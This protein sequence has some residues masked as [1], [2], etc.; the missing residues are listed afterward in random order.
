VNW[1]SRG[2]WILVVALLAVFDAGQA[3]ADELLEKYRKPV[4][5]GLDWLAKQQNDKGYWGVSAGNDTYCISM[6]A[7]SGMALLMEGSTI[8]EGKYAANIRKAT[9]FLMDKCQD[10]N[11]RDGLIGDPTLPN[12]Q[13]RYM[14]GH[15]FGLMFL[16]SVYGEEQDAKK[17]ARLKEILTRAVK[18]CINAQSTRGGWYYTSA[19]DGH[20]QDEG[21]VT[22]TQVQALRAARNAGI[23]VPRDVIRKCYEYLKACT[24]PRGAVYYSW[25]SKSERAAITAAAVACLFNAGEYKDELGKKWLLFCKDSIPAEIGGIGGGGPRLGH[26]E[27]THYYYAQCLYILGDGGWE[28]LF[29]PTAPAQRV[30]WTTYRNTLCDQLVR[31][32]NQDGSWSSAGGFSVGPVYSTAM[33]LTIMQLDKG[34]LPIYQR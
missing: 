33:Y 13:A 18:Y 34:V 23:P 7:L 4:E 27:Y 16:A 6:T 1:K 3:R 31:L 26:D 19:K 22:I 14:Y 9:D 8:K 2:R 10:G 28:K 20:D 29:G 24:S 12:E 11:N 15:G 17:R 5:K 30:T 21:S 25:T 32:Q